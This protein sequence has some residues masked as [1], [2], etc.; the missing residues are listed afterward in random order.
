MSLFIAKSESREL[1]M[2]NDKPVSRRTLFAGICGVAVAAIAPLP[3]NANSAIKKL[4]GGR[5]SVQLRKIKELQEIGGSVR[6][7]NVKGKPV[8]ITR[9]GASTYVAFNLLCPH[10]GVTVEK[11]ENGWKC[12]AHGSEFDKDGALSL[13]PATSDL[14]AV[15]MKISRNVATVG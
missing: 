5:L 12:A 2:L 13:G 10:Q 15:P 6:I 9:T 4:S 11:S 14:P 3:A 1:A 8:A 7:G